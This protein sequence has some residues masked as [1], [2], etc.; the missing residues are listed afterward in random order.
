MATEITERIAGVGAFIVRRGSPRHFMAI[1][2]A[3]GK[4]V[5]NKLAG[6]VSAPFETVEPGETHRQA[7]ERALH[8]QG[9]AGQEELVIVGGGILIPDSLDESKLCLVQLSPDVWLHAYL[10]EAT[11]DLAVR[12]GIGDDM[13]GQPEWVGIDEVLRTED[14]SNRFRFR[15]GM[16]EIVKSYLTYTRDRSGFERM[17]YHKPVNLVP[18]SVFDMIE[19]GASQTEALSRL[20]LDEKGLLSAQAPVRL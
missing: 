5:T 8:Q 2:E 9:N 7:L 1:I 13:A 12:R 20:H 3:R 19:A 15:P 16:I 14:G 6:M 11:P 4:R 10:L 18:S 17:V